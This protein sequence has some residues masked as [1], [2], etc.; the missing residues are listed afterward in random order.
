M[1]RYKVLVGVNGSE[2]HTLDVDADIIVQDPVTEVI[3]FRRDDDLFPVAYVP[4]ARIIYIQNMTMVLDNLV[5]DKLATGGVV[6]TPWQGKNRP[7]GPDLGEGKLVMHYGG[8][9]STH[10][11]SKYEIGDDPIGDA[12]RDAAKRFN[13]QV[14][15]TGE[16]GENCA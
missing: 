3:E 1:S 14:K 8:P 15:A 16:L 6:S 13:I 9:V 5:K 7:G 2:Y 10:R 11:Y 12:A 4:R